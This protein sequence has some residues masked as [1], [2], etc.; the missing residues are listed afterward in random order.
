VGVDHVIRH[1]P[2]AAMNDQNGISRQRIPRKKD[3]KK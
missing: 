2:R 1:G 3:K